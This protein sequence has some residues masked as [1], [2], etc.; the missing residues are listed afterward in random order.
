M[1]RKLFCLLTLLLTVCS[2]AW[3]TEENLKADDASGNSYTGTAYNFIAAGTITT[4]KSSAT[5]ADDN[6]LTF[7]KGWLPS[8]S[9]TAIGKNSYKFTAKKD[10]TSLKIYYTFSDSNFGSKDQSKSASL[11][12]QI[13]DAD[14]VTLSSVAGSNKVAYVATITNINEDDVIDLYSSGSRLVVF[15]VYATYTVV[16][17][18]SVSVAYNGGGS[19]GTA[20][21][22]SSTIAEGATTTITAVPESGY[23]VTNWAVSGTGASIDPNGA[24]NSLT[25]TL[26]MGTADAEVTVT[27]GAAATYSVTHTLSNVTK[28][29]GETTATEGSNYT[30]V[31]AAN[32]GYKLPDAITVTIGGETKTVDTDYTW[33]KSTGTVTIPAANVTGAIVITVTGVEKTAPV[34]GTVLSLTMK[35]ATLSSVTQNT[36]VNL[37]DTY[38]TLVDCNAYLGNKNS[39]AT[40]AQITTTGS[41]TVYFNGNDAYIKIESDFPLKTGDKLTFVNGSG[42]NQI[43]FT[44]TNTRATTAATSSNTYTFSSGFNDVSTIYIWRSGSGTYLHSLTVTRFGVSYNANG[45]SGTMATTSNVVAACTFTAPDGKAFKEW[46]TAKDG[47]GTTYEE[48]DVVAD[49]TTLYAIWD[50]AITVTSSV[51]NDAYGSVTEGG[52][53]ASGATPSFIATPNDG[54]YFSS[55]T[56]DDVADASTE[57]PYTFA[58]LTTSHTIQAV[59]AANPTITFSKGES[60]ALGTVP[61]AV[62][63]G[64]VYTL[65][66]APLLYKTGYTLTAWNDGKS[67]HAVGTTMDVTGDV[68]LTPVFTAN[69]ADPW[70][71]AT[72]VEWTFKTSE[73]APEINMF[74]SG[75]TV[76]SKRAII[77]ST[78]YDALMTIDATNGKFDNSTNSG[79]AQV[80]ANTTFTIPAVKNMVV[81][82]NCNQI[83]DA[84]SNFTFDGDE[85]DSFNASSTPRTLTYQYKGT[86][87]SI[88]IV[89]A[90]DNLYPESIVVN[91]PKSRNTVIYNANGGTCA[92][93]SDTQASAGASLTLPTPT[94]DGCTFDGWYSAGSKVGDAGNSYTPDADITL[95]AKWTD[96]IEGKLF[97]YIDGNYGDK[98]KAFDGSGW[99]ADDGETVS[100]KNKTFTHATTGAQFVVSDGAWDGKT[101]A[102]SALAKFVSGTSG[103]SMSVVIPSGYVAKVKILYGAYNKSRKLT[104]NEVQQTDPNAALNDSHTTAQLKGDL[105]EVTLENQS[106]TLNLGSSE[107]NIYIARVAV[108]LITSVNATIASSGWTSL[109]SAYEL[110]FS[111]AEEQES[112]PVVAYAI[113]SIKKTSVTLTQHDAAPAGVGMILKGNPS[114]TYSIP[115][116]TSVVSFDN[117]LSAAV[118]ATAVEANSVYAVSGGKLKLFTGTEV[119]AGKAYLLANKVPKEARGLSLVFDEDGEATGIAEINSKKGLLDGDFYDLSGRKVAQ[120]TKGLYIMNGR[121]VIVK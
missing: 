2:G 80:N 84:T 114:S 75:S 52:T 21:A 48:G 109:A 30:A 24:S 106:G 82:I 34:S 44:T 104:V 116:T 76:Y 16:P 50:D 86:E 105:T 40:K 11:K 28:T 69:A 96:N 49:N 85:A 3:A 121:K 77:G 36:E 41:G 81:T 64:G 71:T 25:T 115:V 53:Y 42:S 55:W 33:N 83:P 54:Y 108:E 88:D 62:S 99:V 19:Y 45:G 89:C 98:F 22:A 14:A 112:V 111:A 31:F 97:S 13:G 12:Y 67:D 9:S 103:T 119:P 51:N 102:I 101:N 39:D 57:N 65:P 37:A 5:A 32:S 90:K 68:T 58:A 110:D 79:Y 66:A 38:A 61:A 4:D 72:E 1:K 7:S 20:S 91:Y 94:Y 35:S 43:C 27:F 59:F 74:L 63:F 15:A 46:N 17:T 92:T 18:H 70:T 118:N 117:E 73:G 120:P 113:S 87:S 100:G 78:P 10:I 95:Y 29:N 47:N 60:G 26:T 107:G 93:A 6:T 8:G 56:I 23:K